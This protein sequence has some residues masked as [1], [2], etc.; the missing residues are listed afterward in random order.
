MPA[1]A[2]GE[3]CRS[4]P[5][6][7]LLAQ[8]LGRLTALEAAYAEV[9]MAQA[10]LETENADLRAAVAQ[11]SEELAQ[12]RGPEWREQVEATLGENERLRE[13]R[14]ALRNEVA[15]LKG[16]Q[17]QPRFL[18]KRPHS[19]D[20]ERQQ[21]PGEPRRQATRA[22]VRI[23]RT[24]VCT[25]N[26]AALP[27]DAEFKGYAEVLVQEVVLQTD[28]V[29]YRCEKYYAPSTGKAYQAPLPVGVQP[30]YGPGLRSLVLYW[31]YATN[32]S[33]GQIRLL[34]TSLGVQISAGT[35]ARMVVRQPALAA[36]AAAVRHAGVA[37]S[38]YQHLDA[39]VTRLAGAD[40]ACHVLGTTLYVS[41]TTTPTKDRLAVL[42][43]LQLGAPRTYQ[44]NP[45]ATA[46]LT[47]VPTL[48]K[49]VQCGLAR[50]PQGV[51]WD[52]AAFSALLDSAL[53]GL[54]PVQRGRVLDAA[55]IGAYRTQTIVPVVETLVVDG[56]PQF[57]GCT[58]DLQL[59]WVHEG[60]HYKKLTPHLALHQRLLDAVLTAF[61]DYYHQL[62]AY[63]RAPSPQ[64][65]A[66]LRRAFDDLFTCQTGYRDLDDRLRLTLAKQ[67]SLL[68]VLDKPELP[69]ENNLAERDC[70]QR[71]RKRDAS[72]GARSPAGLRAWDDLQTLIGTAQK[73]GVNVLH[74]LRDRLSGACQL[75]ALADL[76]QQRSASPATP[77]LALAA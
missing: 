49:W 62:Q 22:A 42:D 41:Y 19:S 26:R 74:Y 37:S 52:Q 34:L 40:Y 59:C 71:V 9:C 72:G 43:V 28:T 45:Y 53:P 25:L 60:R 35:I 31:S 27:A 24:E 18:P 39:T 67:H 75:P 15:R 54:G 64:E 63:R 56:A 73:L 32:T 2:V 7:A 55:A 70:R 65:A 20:R 44:L 17:G 58:P 38:P 23:D 36:E 21:P 13:E 1:G 30:G 11:L 14:Q 69:I 12:W 8:V 68:R 50:L 76:I 57:A 6:A 10:T 61:W 5:E 48:P 29:C 3:A 77:C 16:E 33:Q 51:T 46:F 66:R 47:T 4:E